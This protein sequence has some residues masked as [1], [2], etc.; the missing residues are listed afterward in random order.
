M[1]EHV[2][3]RLTVLYHG[4][5]IGIT[6]VIARSDDDDESDVDRAARVEVWGFEPLPG[7]ETVASIVQ[8]A[9]DASR[10]LGYLGPAADSRFKVAGEAAWAA[11]ETLC[12]ELELHD[13]DGRVVPARIGMLNEWK[14]KGERRF[15]LLGYLRTGDGPQL[16]SP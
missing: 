3:A 10:D 7:Y 15:D 8:R 9:Q 5:P 16:P 13:D 2:L 4:A 12:A 14:S 1:S 6:S 11:L